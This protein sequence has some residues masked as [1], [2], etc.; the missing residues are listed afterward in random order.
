VR[1]EYQPPL[2]QIGA[3]IAKLFGEEPGMQVEDD[4]RRFK[5]KLE[6]GEAPTTE[7]QPR[8]NAPQSRMDGAMQGVRR[9]ADAAASLT[10]TR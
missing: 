7:Q 6:A 3:T 9:L 4:L 1:I 5:A 10:G 2:G 8:G